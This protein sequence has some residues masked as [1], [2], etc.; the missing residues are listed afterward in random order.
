MHSLPVK[1]WQLCFG[2]EKG[3]FLSISWL[4]GPQSTLTGI[5]RHWQNSA[6]DSELEKTD[7]EQGRKHSQWQRSIPRC[8]Q[9][10]TLLQRFGWKITLYSGLGTQRLPPVSEDERTFIRNTL[11]QRRRGDRC[12]STLPQ[13]HGG[14]LVWYEHTKT[15][16]TPTEMFRSKRR[17]CKKWI[18]VQVWYDVKRFE[19]KHIFICFKK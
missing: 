14:E 2:I 5:K 9:T 12:G 8:P 4:Q 6:G 13:K 10:V 11:Q 18:N 17:L 1:S 19:N 7:A 16:N 15:S 3:Y